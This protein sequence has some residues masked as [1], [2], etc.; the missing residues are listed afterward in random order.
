MSQ[1][2]PLEDALKKLGIPKEQL[3]ELREQGVLR[4][5]RDGT[6]WKFRTDEIED[7]L[8]NPS[9]MVPAPSSDLA[10]D[11]DLVEEPSTPSDSI[12]V[13]D[14]E[15]GAGENR[16]PSTVIGKPNGK[17]GDSDLELRLESDLD[18]GGASD[19]SLAT[20]SDVLAGSS[21]SHI[22]GDASPTPSP[23]ASAKFEDLDE[24]EIDLEAESSKI[25][26]ESEIG[27]LGASGELSELSLLGSDIP[28]VASADNAD[29]DALSDDDL[30][31][32]EGGSDITL[33]AG[34]SGIGLG[35][36]SDSGLALDDISM[37]LSGVGIEPLELAE[38]DDQLVLEDISEDDAVTDLKA[39]DDF[40]LTPL[41][42]GL[43]ADAE[44]DSGSQVI[45]LDSSTDITDSLLG[46]EAAAPVLQPVDAAVAGMGAAGIVAM[47]ATGASASPSDISFDGWTMAL[48]V[49]SVITIGLGGMMMF[50]I[51]RSMW[52]W[53]E[54]FS[55]NSSLIEMFGLFLKK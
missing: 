21:S 40:S 45:A 44:E 14:S 38:A 55:V 16:P 3:N 18:L 28:L 51:L 37:D 47:G 9:K 49:L 41:A 6:S 23:S 22:L 5:Y 35:D 30:V 15:I 20:P 10:L 32:S 2:I 4:G 39:E 24:L 27:K 34:D 17:K 31:L 7:M 50:D 25:L 1:L 19:V 43:V 48:L 54:P 8:A 13:S 36:P 11:L 52:S 26:S 42:D 46:E 33:S 53:G 29:E 12:L